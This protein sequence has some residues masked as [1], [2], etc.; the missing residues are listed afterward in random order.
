MFTAVYCKYVSYYW[1]KLISDTVVVVVMAAVVIVTVCCEERCSFSDGSEVS[2]QLWKRKSVSVISAVT[3]PTRPERV[4]GSSGRG[5][6]V[7]VRQQC[8]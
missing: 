4:P 1:F 2:V 3:S 6:G 7:C 8:V 5:G